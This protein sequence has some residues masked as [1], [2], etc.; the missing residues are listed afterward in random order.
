MSEGMITSNSDKSMSGKQGCDKGP[1]VCS[2]LLTFL[3]VILVL[4]TLPFSLLFVVKVVQVRESIRYSLHC[5]C[6][7]MNVPWSFVS[8]YFW[9]EAPEDPEFSSFFP[10]L[11]F[12]RRLICAR[13]HSMFLR[14]R[15]G[16]TKSTQFKI[17]IRRFWR[18]TV[19]QY[20]LTL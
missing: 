1:G 11:M 5:V 12:T 4:A 8:D 3:S 2:V 16:N 10:V 13:K 19:S 7:S 14:K 18:K 20:L 15:L 9:Q 17:C 6:R